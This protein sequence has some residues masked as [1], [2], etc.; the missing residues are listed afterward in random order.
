MSLSRRAFLKSTA[1]VAIATGSL[2]LFGLDEVFASDTV[3]IPHASHYGP[4]KAVVRNGVL[5]GVQPL[6][7]FDPM[8]TQ[9]LLEG[10]LSRTY[11]PT[12]VQFPMVRRSYLANPRGDTR[13]HRQRA[14]E[15]RLSGQDHR[16]LQV[17]YDPHAQVAHSESGDILG[18][19][20]AVAG[21]AGLRAVQLVGR[22][23]SGRRG[24]NDSGA[25]RAGA[26]GAA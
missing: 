2:R 5:I 16:Q 23:R 9:M 6:E 1:A 10:V 11:H 25:S 18:G 21:R 12:R 15:L 19:C 26:T 22:H 17:R 3:L 20:A 13:P 7:G 4:F 24:C 8:P 14:T